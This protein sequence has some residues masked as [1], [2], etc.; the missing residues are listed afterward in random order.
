M[1]Y[2]PVIALVA[3]IIL[4]SVV[5]GGVR[6]RAAARRNTTPQEP[7]ATPQG[8]AQPAH[9][10]S[11]E[12]PPT[13]KSAMVLRSIGR[14]ESV[15]SRLCCRATQ[16][17]EWI[18]RETDPQGQ[19]QRTRTPEEHTRTHLSPL[20]FTAAERL[21]TSLSGLTAHKLT[22]GTY[23]DCHGRRVISLAERF[24]CFDSYD[25]ATE[26]RYYRWYIIVEAERLTRV[27][28]EDDSPQ[29]YITEDVRD[30]EDNC[31]SALKEL[32]LVL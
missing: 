27:Y 20:P 28:T 4:M 29:L 1:E 16:R 15:R 32:G 3:F 8:E 31:V 5:F 23:L 24:P 6:D 13:E 10:D 2:I 9:P 18:S 21:Y 17:L 11:S 26:N 30:L 14:G 19:P 25:Y 12:P 22:D 7:P